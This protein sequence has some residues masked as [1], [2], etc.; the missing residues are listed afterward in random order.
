MLRFEWGRLRT[1]DSTNAKQDHGERKKRK[2]TTQCTRKRKKKQL[3]RFAFDN[4]M[5]KIGGPLTSDKQ[6]RALLDEG[7]WITRK[8]VGNYVV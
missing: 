7:I 1:S 2:T 6:P 4:A 3:M 8:L 5:W